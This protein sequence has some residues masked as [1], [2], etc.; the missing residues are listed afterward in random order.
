MEDLFTAARLLKIPKAAKVTTVT[1]PCSVRFVCRKVLKR[2]IA[3]SR[4]SGM[5]RRQ[6]T[7]RAA[8]GLDGREPA[9]SLPKGRPSP[10]E[11]RPRR[12]ANNFTGDLWR[13]FLPRFFVS[14]AGRL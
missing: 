13:W 5:T 2:N 1:K 3:R 7:G 4:P 11:P 8:L 12:K 10:H 14:L 9:L 6:K